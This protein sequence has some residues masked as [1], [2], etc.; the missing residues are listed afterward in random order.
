M[1]EQDLKT[2]GKFFKRAREESQLTQEEIATALGYSSKQ[3]VSNWER[4]LCSPPLNQVSK[5][6]QLL[7]LNPEEIVDLFMR[8][9]RSEFEKHIYS[10]PRT[11]KRG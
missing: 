11:V 2:I 7:K 10:K 9:S 5:L 3:I 1:L 8:A 4:G 6:V